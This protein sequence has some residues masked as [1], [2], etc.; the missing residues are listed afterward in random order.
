M[1]KFSE[2]LCLNLANALTGYVKLL[3]NLLQR[4]RFAVVEAIAQA[5]HLRLSLREGVEHVHELLF[6][7][8][9]S[10]R[11]GRRGCVVIGDKIAKVGVVLLADRR[12]Q[13]DGLLRNLDDLAH[14]F[15][16]DTHLFCNLIRARIAS[17]FLYQLAIDANEL[18]NRFHHMHRDTNRTRLI[19][20][21]AGNRLTNPP[22]GIGR[23]LIAFAVVKLL[24]RLD[25]AQVA[26]LNQ[27]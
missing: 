3:A 5:E 8:R 19:R 15:L 27:V 16:G 6:E 22:G 9:N 2:R 13:R 4:A 17:V 25:E 23:E 14:L 7:Q 11:L 12:F 10:N 24:N 18:V 21:C 1:A 26:L 20:N